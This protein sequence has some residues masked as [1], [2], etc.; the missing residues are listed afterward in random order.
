MI[1]SLSSGIIGEHSVKH[2]LD[3]GLRRFKEYGRKRERR[4]F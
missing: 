1:V 2:E 3:I 4:I